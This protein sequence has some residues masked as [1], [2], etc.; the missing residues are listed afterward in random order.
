M[1]LY[2]KKNMKIGTAYQW[3]SETL[4]SGMWVTCSPKEIFFLPT[5]YVGMLQRGIAEKPVNQPPHAILL[6]EGRWKI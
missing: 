6:G 5:K 1:P 4:F 3:A 2:V